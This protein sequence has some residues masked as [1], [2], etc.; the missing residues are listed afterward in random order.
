MTRCS[1]WE[2]AQKG[3]LSISERW[4]LVNE[5][6]R[7]EARDATLE[8]KLEQ[9]A[10]LMASVDDFGWRQ[11]LEEDDDRISIWTECGLPCDSSAR[12]WKARTTRRDWKRS[13]NECARERLGGGAGPTV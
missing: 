8:V 1:L 2:M 3:E 6:L 9:L 4:T 11:K 7:E 5:R 13:C 12:P 10:A